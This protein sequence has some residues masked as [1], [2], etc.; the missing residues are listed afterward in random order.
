MD[1]QQSG[2]VLATL[3]PYNPTDFELRQQ[4]TAC[5]SIIAAQSYVACPTSSLL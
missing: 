4:S 3:Q 5:V 1:S 2:G